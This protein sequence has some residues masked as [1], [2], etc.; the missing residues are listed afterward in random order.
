[1]QTHHS[2]AGFNDWYNVKDYGLAGDGVTDDTAS[3]QSIIDRIAV[4]QRNSV[5]YFP[6]EGPYLIA[7]PLLERDNCQVRFPKVGLNG[8]QYTLTL[9]GC[10]RPTFSPSA[11]ATVPLP[12]G[13][14]I[15]SN[16][17]SGGGDNPSL[18]GGRGVVHDNRFECSY[19]TPGFEGV[20]GSVLRI[21]NCL[22]K[23]AV[24]GFCGLLNGP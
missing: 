11:Y 1:M 13:T 17:A 3:L 16:L 21:K 12:A 2:P 4:T 10:N 22:D 24:V 15:V 8:K 19:M 14:R 18:F 9:K 20:L 5:I 7:G 23:D 6:D